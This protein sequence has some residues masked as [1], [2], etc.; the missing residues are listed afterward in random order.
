MDHLMDQKEGHD[1]EKMAFMDYESVWDE[2]VFLSFF[3]DFLLNF[4]H[5]FPY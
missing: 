1:K 3:F 5:F 4:N 2:F